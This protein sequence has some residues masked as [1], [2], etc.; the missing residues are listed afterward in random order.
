MRK[1][2]PRVRGTRRTKEKIE[3]LKL[4]KTTYNFIA[5]TD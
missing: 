1:S 2:E 4:L 5:D 3:A